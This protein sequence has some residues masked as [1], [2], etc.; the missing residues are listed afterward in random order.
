MLDFSGILRIVFNAH[1]F[2]LR[3]T[4]GT[5]SKPPI[6]MRAICKVSADDALTLSEQIAK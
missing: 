2:F 3:G 4:V 1:Y 6:N 5:I